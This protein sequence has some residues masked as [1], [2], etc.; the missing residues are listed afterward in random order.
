MFDMKTYICVYYHD[1]LE[2]SFINVASCLLTKSIFTSIQ[3]L[4]Q[5]FYHFTGRIKDNAA[6]IQPAV[7]GGVEYARGGA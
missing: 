6:E 5:L 3:P 1:T 4:M 2:M 7:G